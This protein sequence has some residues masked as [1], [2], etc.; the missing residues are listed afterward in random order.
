MGRNLYGEKVVRNVRFKSLQTEGI[1]AEIYI[2]KK[3]SQISNLRDAPRAEL[4]GEIYIHRKRPQIS[5]LKV[6]NR[7][8]WG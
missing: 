1:G 7:D 8:N 6:E 2:Q 4:G 5:N 3:W